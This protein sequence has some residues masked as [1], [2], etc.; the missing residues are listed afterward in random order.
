M[1][2]LVIVNV[3]KSWGCT[4]AYLISIVAN[5]YLDLLVKLATRQQ[6]TRQRRLEIAIDDRSIREATV[7]CQADR[8]RIGELQL[9][10]RKLTSLINA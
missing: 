9:S 7:R 2:R 1:N 8:D 5:H 3:F 4:Q 10:S 6:L